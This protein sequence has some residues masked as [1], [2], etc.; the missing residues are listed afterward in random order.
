RARAEVATVAAVSLAVL[1]ADVVSGA[2]LQMDS[3]LGYNPLVAGRFAGIG[4]IAFSVLGAA[5]VVLAAQVARGRSG[6]GAAAGVLVVAVPVVVIDGWPRWG[7][8]VG[9]VLTLVPAFAVLALLVTGRRVRAVH[10]LAAGAAGAAAAGVMGWL[11]Y[12][13]PPDRRSHFGRFV[14]TALEGGALG[15][16]RRK[17]EASL[18]LLVMGPHTVAAAVA[19]V[20]LALVIVR[21]PALLRAAYAVHPC[22]RPMHLATLVL[23][24]VGLAVNDSIVAVPMVVVLVAGPLTLVLCAS[25][26]VVGPVAPPY[27]R[28]PPFGGAA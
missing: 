19:T 20:L 12:L 26:A 6:R 1:A 9:G 3:L 27:A 2:R 23:A 28:I 16:I 10:A 18:D 11:D 17:A 5:A 4:N 15:T 7:A 8:D 14:G 22:L 21:P 24:G 25:E 13:Q